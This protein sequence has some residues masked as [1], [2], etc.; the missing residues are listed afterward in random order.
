[1][2]CVE[3]F[4]SVLHCDTCVVPKAADAEVMQHHIHCSVLQYLA[5]C[6]S[7]CVL[8]CVEVCFR[9]NVFNTGNVV[10][11]VLQC[12]AVCCSVLQC[13]AAC[14]CCSMLQRVAA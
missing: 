5:L 9:S 2:Q 14:V 3:V 11:G 12:V 1:M 8:Q 6:C 4:C 7:V 13:V 10:P